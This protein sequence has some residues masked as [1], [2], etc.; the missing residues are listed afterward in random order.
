[1]K[2]LINDI[3]IEGVRDALNILAKAGTEDLFE[4]A[5]HQIGDSHPK[6]PQLKWT[7]LG[8]GK[9]GWR[10]GTGKGKRGNT[11][12]NAGQAPQ[13]KPDKTDTTETK[14]DKKLRPVGTGTNGPERRKEASQAKPAKTEKDVPYENLNTADEVITYAKTLSDFTFKDEESGVKNGK[15][16]SLTNKNGLKM[17]VDFVNNSEYVYDFEDKDGNILYR[18]MVT[19]INNETNWK[20]KLN[21]KTWSR[22]M[23]SVTESRISKYKAN[24]KRAKN[25]YEYY[26]K[27]SDYDKYLREDMWAQRESH[28]LEKIKKIAELS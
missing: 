19:R 11:G 23:I 17:I 20:D 15:A 6:W 4:K 27:T 21:P 10:T 13:A 7:D 18:L 2:N 9:F 22:Q 1:M 26:G 24:A 3:E 8:N 14:E 12:G 16:F 5:K 25:R 28:T